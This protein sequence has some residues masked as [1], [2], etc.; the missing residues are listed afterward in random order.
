MEQN[1]KPKEVACE[2]LIKAIKNCS[3]EIQEKVLKEYRDL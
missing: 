2:K 3:D 1:L